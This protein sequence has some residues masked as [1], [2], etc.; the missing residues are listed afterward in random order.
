MWET[1][2]LEGKSRFDIFSTKVSVS[3]SYKLC[4]NSLFFLTVCALFFFGF[5]TRKLNSKGNESICVE[6]GS[7]SNTCTGKL[8]EVEITCN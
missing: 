5:I 3:N 8:D 7:G 4:S 2:A 1:P 6:E